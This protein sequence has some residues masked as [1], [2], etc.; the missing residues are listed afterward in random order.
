M[1]DQY[2]NLGEAIKKGDVETG[3]SESLLLVERGVKPIEIFSECI[4]PT[5]A[6]IGD[7]FSRLEI[8]L[9]EMINSAEVV[10]AIQNEFKPLMEADQE[11]I[12]KGKI[13]IAT[14]SGDLHDIG[15]NI[16][17]AMLEVNGFEVNDLGV[18]VET[19]TILK[20]ARD[21]DADIIALSALMIPSLPFV[22]DVIDFI[23]ANEEARS[24]FKVMVGGGPVN[25]EWADEAGADG[26]GDDAIEA[27]DVAYR[28]IDA[29]A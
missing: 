11:T 27:V 5:L 28:L 26:Y 23:E 16:V 8:F 29:P 6:V 10:K 15:K 22:K 3:V 2:V 4:E 18:D 14:V 17:K 25:R 9:P 7:Q 24:R 12:S 1:T 20:S 13:V 19:K 21:A